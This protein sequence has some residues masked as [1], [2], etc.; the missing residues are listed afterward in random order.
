M[1]MRPYYLYRQKYVAGNLEN[2]AY[3][4]PGRECLYNMDMMEET[5]SVLA[6]GAGAISKRIFPKESRIER[7]PNAGDIGH[8]L[9][10]I[11][12]MILRKQKLWED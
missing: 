4:L 10:R 9:S 12:D 11:Q 6:V 7:A 2:V 1:G 8:Y 3:A 5:T